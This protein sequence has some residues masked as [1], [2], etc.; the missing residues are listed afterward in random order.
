MGS[1]ASRLGRCAFCDRKFQQ[2]S[3]PGRR[4]AYCDTSCRR[5]AQ[6][7]RDRERRMPPTPTRPWGRDV[8]VDVHAL[9]VELVEAEL[10]G[11]NLKKVLEY[12]DQLER[13]VAYY[14]AAAIRDA[15]ESGHTWEEIAAAF[16]TGTETLRARF[17]EPQLKRLFARRAKERRPGWTPRTGRQPKTSSAKP[18]HAPSAM[19]VSPS[20]RLGAALSHLQRASS[21]TV[22][23]AARQADLSPSYVSRILAGERIPTWPV[24][25]MLTKIF[26]G[27]PEE[28]RILW[29]DAQ[30]LRYPSRQD[31][32]SAAQRLHAALRGLH[33]AAGRPGISAL[34]KKT[35]LPAGLIKATLNGEHVPDWPTTARL[36]TSMTA[37]PSS[38]RPLWEAVHYAFLACHDIFPAGGLPRPA[39]TG[40]T[41]DGPGPAEP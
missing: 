19:A 13:E 5:R 26:E 18:P 34:A 41:G 31:Q 6:R 29:E 37:D 7:E 11:T 27:N 14:R 4:K 9:A 23:D 10:R 24:T 39:A 25:Y 3:G 30:G 28:T 2:R 36:T 40:K 35:S 12:A 15:R 8:A 20:V 16:G 17:S 32:D 1:S 38:I 21:V 33:L 22:G